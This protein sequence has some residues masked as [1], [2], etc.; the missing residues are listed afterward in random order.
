V[1]AVH[2]PTGDEVFNSFIV[3]RKIPHTEIST[4]AAPTIN[5]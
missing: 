1:L 3:A 5:G 2:H 4:C